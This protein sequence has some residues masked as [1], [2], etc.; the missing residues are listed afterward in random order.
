[1]LSAA[2]I[3]L[4]VHKLLVL[5]LSLSIALAGMPLRAW[6]DGSADLPVAPSIAGS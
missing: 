1:M 3:R 5:T 6:G 4:F 2:M